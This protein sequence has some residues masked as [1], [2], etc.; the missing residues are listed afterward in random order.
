MSRGHEWI[1]CGMLISLTFTYQ[2]RYHLISKHTNRTRKAL[3]SKRA[4]ARNVAALVCMLRR[5]G[6]KQRIFAFMP[7]IPFPAILTSYHTGCAL[8]LLAMQEVTPFLALQVQPLRGSSAQ[9]SSC[10]PPA[11]CLPPT[12]VHH[13]H[14][15]N[16]SL[17]CVD[18]GPRTYVKN[19]GH[20][21]P[22]TRGH[23]HRCMQVTGS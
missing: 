10:A 1:V 19:T 11:R 12:S 22:G 17:L 13:P 15:R 2:R 21:I 20:S 9:T 16:S 8:G 4:K 18:P 6:S 23:L 5:N 7:I 14:L 3:H